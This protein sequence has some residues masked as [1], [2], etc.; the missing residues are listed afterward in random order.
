VSTEEPP[1]LDLDELRDLVE[2]GLA[3]YRRV[4]PASAL[5]HFLGA[6]LFFLEVHPAALQW[7]GVLRSTRVARRAAAPTDAPRPED[8]VA[9]SGTILD[10]VGTCSAQGEH[11]AE[12]V[13]H[14]A[15]SGLRYLV[16]V[17]FP[18]AETP[19]E[20]ERALRHLI[21]LAL[22]ALFSGAIGALLR[23]SQDDAP[24]V[25]RSQLTL[26]FVSATALFIRVTPKDRDA[27]LFNRYFISRHRVEAGAKH[28]GH[29]VAEEQRDIVAFVERFARALQADVPRLA[30]DVRAVLAAKASA[31]TAPSRPSVARGVAARRGAPRR[32]R[33]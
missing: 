29:S 11:E 13:A 1:S 12:L 31:P 6:T 26:A 19:A 16:G 3:P 32:R 17:P 27:L 28:H 15:E 7:Q 24:G 9:R 14:E 33:S 22:A 8:G 30:R 23:R 25:D 4:L 18:P 2:D 5:R 20:G 10:F 21:E